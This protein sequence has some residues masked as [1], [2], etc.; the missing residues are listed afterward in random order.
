MGV[1]IDLGRDAAP[2]TPVENGT[3][4]AVCRTVSLFT[5]LCR[6]GYAIGTRWKMISKCEECQKCFSFVVL[7]AV[8]R[9]KVDT[10]QVIVFLEP[11]TGSQHSISD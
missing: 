6:E 9:E 1:S 2:T 10:D 11:D 3:G 8:T 7:N 4:G 5:V